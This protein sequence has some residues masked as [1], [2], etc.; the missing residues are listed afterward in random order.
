[1]ETDSKL[2]TKIAHSLLK[3]ILICSTFF[4]FLG[5]FFQ[6][7]IDY[8]KDIDS[9]NISLGQIDRSYSNSLAN[10]LW[11]LDNDQLEIQ[12]SGI[13]KLRDIAFIRVE[14]IREGLPLS[15]MEMGNKNIKNSL[16]KIIPLTYGEETKDRSVIGR[17]YI[18]VNL[19]NI[20]ERL[21]DKFFVIL[22]TQTVKTFIVSF[23]ILFITH[24]LVTKKIIKI[25]EYANQLSVKN[26]DTPLTISDKSFL[27]STSFQKKKDE[28]DA[29]VQ[30]LNVMRINLKSYLA[31]RSE[32]EIQL[33]EYKNHLES[34]VQKRT[35]ELN[36]KNKVLELQI[37]ENKS[38]QNKLIAQ[39]KLASLGNLTSGIAHELNN[40]LNFIINFAKASNDTLVDFKK[41][42]SSGDQD[43][44]NSPTFLEDL[45]DAIEM[46]FEITEHGNRAE[47]I[48]RSMLEHSRSS[49]RE[50]TSENI[51]VLIEENLNFAY[52]AMKA[53]N[54]GFQVELKSILDKT[55]PNIEI[56]RGDIA[57]VLLNIFTNALYSVAKKYQSL[58]DGPSI[59]N[60]KPYLQVATH[61]R[62]GKLS[63][64]I[65]DNGQGID[66]DKINHIFTPFYTTKP[67]GEGTGLGLSLSYDIIVSIH[68]GQIE[69]ESEVGEYARFI[70]TLPIARAS[71]S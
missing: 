26:L 12:L 8:R 31:K 56:I 18:E 33:R 1:M 45:D 36:E 38:I 46:T 30:S 66:K 29:L 10:S 55:L 50:K 15:Y 37:E 51:N 25:S 5:T 11:H 62:E 16:K 14:E 70:I 22:T 65:E 67:T 24:L 39:E 35:R 9:I 13:L 68:H 41:S 20:Y 6:L 21:L 40:P 44:V 4:T 52:H 42:L 61:A 59:K 7:Y 60:F 3:Y 43:C 58:K 2:Q 71:L 27:R 28:I 53:K 49:S 23:C 57:R 63:I 69:I 32:A 54:N 48:I 19:D 34:L 64:V 17:I 47:S